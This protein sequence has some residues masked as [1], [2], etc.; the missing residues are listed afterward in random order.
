MAQYKYNTII[1]I[2]NNIHTHTRAH[3]EKHG[4]LCFDVFF[5]PPPPPPPTFLRRCQIVL[6]YAAPQTAAVVIFTTSSATAATTAT[7]ESTTITLRRRRPVGNESSRVGTGRRR[8]II[9]F[10]EMLPDRHRLIGSLACTHLLA[11]LLLTYRQN[12]PTRWFAHSFVTA[13]TRTCR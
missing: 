2:C 1:I 7:R 3:T 13:D 10:S 11:R 8:D 6:P 9:R 12:Q 5:F 4:Q